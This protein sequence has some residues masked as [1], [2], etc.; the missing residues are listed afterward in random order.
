MQVM[1]ILSPQEVE[2][3]GGLP[4]E[5]IAG[6]LLGASPLDGFRPNPGF[7]AFMHDVIRAAGPQ[8]ESLQA[9]ALEQGDGYVFI[10]DLRTPDGPQGPV[11]PEDIIGAFQVQNG[12]ILPDRYEA[13]T[14]YQVL[15]HNGL[16]HL[17]PSLRAAFVAMLP[18]V[19]SKR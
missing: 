5:A 4:P 15:T 7:T 9:V 10:I 1:S 17:P 2:A 3:L 8:D 11:P 6:V 12:R 14:H 13:N 18:R 16:V 19:A